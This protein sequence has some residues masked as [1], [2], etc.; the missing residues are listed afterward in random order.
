MKTELIIF[1]G[2]DC[3]GKTTMLD[4][5]FEELTSKKYKCGKFKF[6]VYDG[7]YG[8]E[9]LDHL[10]NYDFDNYSKEEN[11]K[12][13]MHFSEISYM[14]KLSAFNDF[15]AMVNDNDYDFILLDRFALSQYI[16]DIAWVEIYDG[17]YIK[18]N[19][20]RMKFDPDKDL[21]ENCMYTPKILNAIRRRASVIMETYKLIFPKITTFVFATNP[22]VKAIV[23]Y[24]RDHD[25]GDRRVDV[26]DS[27]TRYQ[28]EVSSLM[29]K[30]PSCALDDLLGT[31]AHL[32]YP[33]DMIDIPGVKPVN[34]YLPA[35]EYEKNKDAFDAALKKYT[36][37]VVEFIVSEVT[38]DK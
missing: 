19:F 26:Y 13:L 27:L 12:E 34:G 17:Q 22:Y 5:V 23:S 3:C 35:S 30:S 25:K 38:N 28:Q 6:P 20:N 2:G 31:K 7:M 14:N 4:K 1:E 24:N 32:I 16:Y 11:F 15:M 29:V 8:K 9:I 21:Y 10:K 18:N 37:N 33:T 36:E